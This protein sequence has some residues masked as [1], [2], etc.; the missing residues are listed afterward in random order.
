MELHSDHILLQML[1]VLFPII[2]HQALLNNRKLEEK[3]SFYWGMVFT[4]TMGLCLAFAIKID[5]GVFL[6]L[7]MV[8][9]FLGFI[10]GGKAV[11]IFVTTFYVVVR[12]FVGGDGMIPAFI[13]LLL[14]SLV[15]WRF[16]SYYLKW[17][18]KKKILFSILFLI[19]LS[20]LIP[21]F[22]TILLDKSLT[23]SRLF[24]NIG[25]VT[26]NAITLWLAVHLME[27]YQEKQDLVKEIQKNEKLQVVGQVAASVA[28]EIRN[29][30]TSVRGFIQLL[31]AS[32][33]ININEKNQ[34][35]LC[36][37]E[38]DRAN[39]IISDYLSLGKNPELEQHAVL[40][41]TKL[42]TRSVDTLTSY[43]TINGVNITIDACVNAY[44]MGNNGRFQQMLVNL[45]KNGIEAA[46]PN[47]YVKVK[48]SMIDQQVEIIV[49]DDGVGMTPQQMEN[50][51][52]PYYS[53]KEKGTGLGLMVTLQIIKEMNGIWNVSSQQNKGTAFKIYFPSVKN[54]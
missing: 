3:E 44:V 28:H 11:G 45:I 25:F 18:R 53:T 52:L 19:I 30:M 33:N 35:Q 13:V 24:I 22:G 23:T 8:P 26:T 32:K 49:E 29:P 9:W 40:D 51:G 12:F 16:R 20:S 50:I 5:D 27:S 1:M 48:V 14:G 46:R 34:L 37:D 7:R 31:S 17:E 6:D 38:L 36:L 15:I 2:L 47:G 39:A 21:V 54:E 43:A 4:V 10:Y 42:A 41:I